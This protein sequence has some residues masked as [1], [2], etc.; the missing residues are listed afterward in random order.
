MLI[1]DSSSFNINPFRRHFKSDRFLSMKIS[2][3]LKKSLTPYVLSFSKIKYK[4]LFYKLESIFMN[5]YRFFE[6]F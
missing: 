5:V 2:H 1:I 6:S 3:N 4:Q